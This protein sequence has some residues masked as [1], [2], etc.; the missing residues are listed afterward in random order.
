M[1]DRR[2]R[3]RVDAA[4]HA[5]WWS[6][7]TAADEEKVLAA[8]LAAGVP[9]VALVASR[10]RGDAVLAGVG[11]R[12]RSRAHA[13]PALDIGARTAPEVAVSI[14]AEIIATR[15]APPPAPHGDCADRRRSQATGPSDRP[16]DPGDGRDR[17]GLRHDVA[18]TPTRAR[19]TNTAD[20]VL[21][22]RLRLQGGVH[23]R[24]AP[25]L[26]AHGR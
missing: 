20:D 5:A 14:L 7:R 23:R 3:T 17:P 21:L 8:A 22:L 11:A 18:V 1:V 15:P 24:P 6:R 13:R 9:Y 26:T 16:H 10:K 19:S 4:G 25:Y 12:P 2:R